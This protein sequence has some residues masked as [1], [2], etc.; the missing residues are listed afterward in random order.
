[1]RDA[2][3][4]TYLPATAFTGTDTYI[5]TVPDGT[6]LVEGTVTENVTAAPLGLN[7]N[8]PPRLELLPGGEV[9]A[10]FAGIPGRAYHL[11]RSIN[12]GTWTTIGT[13]TADSTGNVVFTDSAPPQPTA[14]YRIAY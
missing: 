10:S 3:M 12:L 4:I 2:G 9:R 1:V 6:S 5:V 11:Q 14:F 8:N 7:N 13:T